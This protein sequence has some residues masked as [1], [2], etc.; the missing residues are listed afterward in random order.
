MEIDEQQRV[1]M[2]DD[3]G[4]LA[5]WRPLRFFRRGKAGDRQKEN[6]GWE[7]GEEAGVENW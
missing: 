4:S 7:G 1:T 6:T 2:A 5:V 3:R